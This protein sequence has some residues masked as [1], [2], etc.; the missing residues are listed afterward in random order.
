M[1]KNIFIDL[2]G[3]NFIAALADGEKLLEYHTEKA[4]SA[5]LVGNIYKGKVVTVLSGMHAA[6]INIGLKKNAYL[7]AGDM[8][9][10]KN[11]ISDGDLP[12]TL[13][14]K[15]GDE[16]L[17]QIVK[18]YVGNKGVKC[19]P[20]L[21]YAGVYLVYMPSFD[22]I[23]VSRKITDE[24]VRERLIATVNSFKRPG[25]GG[26]IVRTAGTT[27]NK[28]VLKKEAELLYKKHEQTLAVSE[29]SPAPSLIYEESDLTER[30][31]RDVYTQ[32]VEKI[33]FGSRELYDKMRDERTVRLDEC[34]KK[35]VLFNRSTDMFKHF[36][37][38]KEVDKLLRNR[39]E[40]SSGAYIII[41]RTEALTV[42]D[43]NT[44][45][46]T[47]K[48]DLEETVFQTNM[49]ATQEI[50]RQVRL[51]N[52]G[53]IVVVDYIDM[54]RAEHRNKVV[55]ALE[56]ALKAD[57]SKCNVLGM[58]GLGLVEFT[59]KKKR[60]ESAAS[61]VQQC[62]YCAGD[63]WIYSNDYM[64]LKIRTALLDVFAEGYASAIIDLNS[65]LT[66]YILKRGSLSVDVKKIWSDKRIYVVPHRTY[67]VESFRVRGD[68][69]KI[70]DLP[71]NA[72]LLF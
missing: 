4:D 1:S 28:R 43:V 11:D 14:M 63:G 18:D 72:R 47:G 38:D 20:I 46:Y 29:S 25:Q 65:D 30:V 71:D 2:N 21:S 61:L 7:N 41:D 39:V 27:V 50:A 12:T 15:E 34:S 26:F 8:L 56:N 54:A 66:D 31:L 57:R 45:K 51:R 10:D 17:V 6:F 58:S 24:A 68:N 33:Y 53:G 44:G 19:S 37:L 64:V 36:G 60:R 55:E 52:I 35:A 67:H 70:L 13:N 40:L 48:D 16:V 59:R 42:I 22:I 3:G 5:N 23:G 9:L 62:P 49:L 69:A 32:E